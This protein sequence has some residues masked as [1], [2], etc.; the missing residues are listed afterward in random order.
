MAEAKEEKKDPTDDEEEESSEESSEEEDSDSDGDGSGEDTDEDETICRKIIADLDKE[1]HEEPP[2][3]LPVVKVRLRMHLLPEHMTM[4]GEGVDN[5][6]VCRAFQLTRKQ[7]IKEILHDYA[8]L[9]STH[10]VNHVG[11]AHAIR[12]VLFWGFM[13]V[14]C[15]GTFGYLFS[16]TMIRFLAFPTVVQISVSVPSSMTTHFASSLLR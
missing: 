10:G 1:D 6:Y 2:E 9:S 3:D 5:S 11:E 16:D 12:V 15:A 7:K 13:L 8:I 4:Y 14:V